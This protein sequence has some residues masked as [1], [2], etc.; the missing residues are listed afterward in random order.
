MSTTLSLSSDSTPRNGA[1][2][3]AMTVSQ[4]V[5]E[6]CEM[7]GGKDI[8]VEVI[9]IDDYSFVG[10][11]NRNRVVKYCFEDDRREEENETLMTLKNSKVGGNYIAKYEPLMHKDKLY[12][13]F[14]LLREISF[15]KVKFEDEILCL[16]QNLLEELRKIHL[17]EIIHGD[18]KENN[19]MSDNGRAVFIDYGCSLHIRKESI[20]DTRSSVNGFV[21]CEM[22]RAPEC[23]SECDENVDK[24]K[25]YLDGRKCDYACSNHVTVQSDVY[26]LGKIFLKYFKNRVEEKHVKFFKKMC[27]IDIESRVKSSDMCR[28][29][30][31]LMPDYEV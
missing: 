10:I 17:C 22:Y 8:S 19:I 25:T 24:L 12:F 28:E 31:G 4:I 7:L 21:H 2:E 9:Q 16:V 6:L 26:A 20:D 18:I 29:W 1:S 27:H 11:I 30:N 14:P 3:N 23:W 15:N 13:S 5:G